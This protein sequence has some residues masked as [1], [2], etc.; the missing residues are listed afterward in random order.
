MSRKPPERRL[1]SIAVAADS[2]DVCNKTIRRWIS[3]GRIAG[4]RVGARLI[5]V[6]LNE[7][8]STFSPIGGKAS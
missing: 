8:E 6:D 4:Y 1:V 5:K 3:E 2:A 7:L